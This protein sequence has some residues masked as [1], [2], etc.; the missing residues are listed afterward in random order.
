VRADIPGGIAIYKHYEAFRQDLPA[1]CEGFKL[2]VNELTF[3]DFS[4]IVAMWLE[5]QALSPSPDR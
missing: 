1:I 5:K 4:A 3:V 2:D